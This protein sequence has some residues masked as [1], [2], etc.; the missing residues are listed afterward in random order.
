M[1]GEPLL[2]TLLLDQA[3]GFVES[4]N[5]R[6]GRRV[7]VSPIGEP[8]LPDQREVEIPRVDRAAASVDHTHRAIVERN[9]RDSRWAPD[10]LLPRAVADV[11]Q[12]FVYGDVGAA[13]RTDRVDEED[14]VPLAHE[15]ADVLQ[16]L[17]DPRRGLAVY[18]GHHLGIGMGIEG[19]CDLIGI[20]HLAKV[21][22][23]P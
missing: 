3:K 8:V 6:S 17:P 22:L 9:T 2:E 13:E 15:F 5:K 19:A 4:V 10:A 11:D 21:D 18:D 23:D 7:M 12:V 16:R 1:A 14:F 20:Q